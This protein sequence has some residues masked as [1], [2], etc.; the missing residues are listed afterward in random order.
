MNR[1]GTEEFKKHISNRLFTVIL[2][3]VLIIAIAA[4]IVSDTRQ[5]IK[6]TLGTLDNV[7]KTVINSIDD[8]SEKVTEKIGETSSVLL[9]KAY[10][11]RQ[12]I[13]TNGGEIS[14]QQLKKF[15][16]EQHLHD[17]LIFDESGK[18]FMSVYPE[19]I[20]FDLNAY[21]ATR[22]YMDIFKDNSI[23]IVEISAVDAD[24]DGDG[25]NYNYCAV[26][27]E[28]GKYIIEVT[29]DANDVESAILKVSVAEVARGMTCD[30]NARTMVIK[31]GRIVSA[32][33]EALIG[34]DAGAFEMSGD[35]AKGSGTFD[36]I[37]CLYSQETDGDYKVL[38]VAENSEVFARNGIGTIVK[39]FCIL[40]VY[41]ALLVASIINRKRFE[42][43]VTDRMKTEQ[44]GK[45]IDAFIRE[46]TTVYR[47][48]LETG[49]YTTLRAMDDVE[50]TFRISSDISANLMNLVN[51]FVAESD[52]ERMTEEFDL[53]TIARK[54]K[55]NPIYSVE[56][57]CLVNLVPEG[58][59]WTYDRAKLDYSVSDN[60]VGLWHRVT[61]SKI[62]ENEVLIGF[63]EDDENIIMKS[64]NDV[65]LDEFD[66]IYAVN[67]VM[68]KM[69]IVKASGLLEGSP[70]VMPYRAAMKRFLSGLDEGARE[71]F[72]KLETEEGFKEL[73]DSGD[74]AEYIY[75]SPYYGDKETWLKA[76]VHVLSEHDGKLETAIFGISPV[77]SIQ[78]KVLS[79]AAAIEHLAVEYVGVYE[80]NLDTEECSIVRIGDRMDPETRKTVQNMTMKQAFKI[81]V[82]NKVHPD[83]RHLLASLL[84]Y[85]LIREELMHKKRSSK[86]FRRMFDDGYKYCNYMVSKEEAI[87]EVPHMVVIGFMMV[88]DRV[89]SE[90]IQKEELARALTFSD[91]IMDSFVS[92]YY[93]DI[94]T[95]EQTTYA[96]T[97][98]LHEKYDDIPDYLDSLDKY[99]A[100]DVH[101][102]DREMLTEAVQPDYIRSRLEKEPYFSVT[103]R[104]ISGGT[105]KNYRCTVIRGADEDHI[106]MAFADVS[107]EVK[108]DAEVREQL[109][110]ALS[111]AQAASK[112]KSTFL[113]N[114]S[115]DIRTPM[116]SIVGYT[117]LA[118]SNIDN[119]EQ[120][121]IYLGKIMNSSN[122]L[123][124]LIN[125]VL[126]MA[127]IESG[128][129]N[130]TET[131]ESLPEILH[132]LHDI[133]ISD[134]NAKQL[135]FYI[136]TVNIRDENVIVDKTRLNQVLL[137][138]LSNA[139]KYTPSGGT[140]FFRVAET[141]VS[142][143]GYGT[144]EFHIKDSGVGM[145][146]EEIS[147]IF[148]PFERAVSADENQIV[149]TGLGMSIV[150]NI[151]DM[152]GGQ[153]E[154][155]SREGQGTE[156]TITLELK[157]EGVQNEPDLIPELKDAR[158]IVVD[159]D[160]N[161]CKSV[162]RM[163]KAIGMQADWCTSGKECLFRTEE[164]VQEGE[165][166]KV[167]IIDWQMPDMNGIETTRQVR[168]LVG[169]DVPVIILTAYDYSDIEEEAREAG[170]S[171]FIT[172]PIF[173]SDLSRTLREVCVSDDEA[174]G[175]AEDASGGA[176]AYDFS[177]K[178]ILIVED[179][180][181]NLDIAE[182]I[183]GELG[184][185]TASAINGK[186]AVEIMSDA[187]P[188]EFDLILMDI[189]MPVMNGLEAAKKIRALDNGVQDIPILALTANAF[190][191]DKVLALEAGMNEHI[192]KPLNVSVLKET[193]AKYL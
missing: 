1:K 135:D 150:K 174:D 55:D 67:L 144:Y 97:D 151:I 164:A 182:K 57:R 11:F 101:P 102:D 127:R 125:D 146:E 73:H 157:L 166:Y 96:R 180:E 178:K 130:L 112:A 5:G 44:S 60:I 103:F 118:A 48:N 172:K 117:G 104:D 75:C 15:V 14:G 175:A 18:A 108:K 54:L 124:S 123:L 23:E 12:L 121:Q 153:I 2:T 142:H 159:D 120:V 179:N 90:M 100:E 13:E 40:L 86:I 66:D 156:V 56:F 71:F 136:D 189:R 92:A 183:L 61:F 29:D 82:E 41:I 106:A 107:E 22:H 176:A 25:G 89:R 93:I 126:D 188:G 16:E 128:K 4:V 114:M 111:L 181:D 33:D 83:D 170:V 171:A 149:G 87:D 167:Y 187:K 162:S 98:E 19:G 84:D 47:V 131:R 80:L 10:A 88:D 139:I 91:F 173:Q 122:H 165:N 190:A 148:T 85:S 65:L 133:V 6:E 95:H 63:V 192:T 9:R 64:V 43:D 3:A 105:E 191:E 161:A 145:S 62:D 31:D 160:M 185:T 69:K 116:N 143:S 132:T 26:S 147:R 186:L 52:R 24:G 76:K 17:A 58:E 59:G 134:V 7:N 184:I 154:V 39:L 94:A 99:I 168:R 50:K 109:Q 46:Y 115:H 32:N 37:P 141:A 113:N 20:G 138:I 21:D 53:K 140:V 38:T 8:Y 74:T 49:E 110:S 68:D 72:S 35:S 30:Y 152:M 158:G 77:D 137:N 51:N 169:D 45:L 70:K 34:R 155:S 36:G 193:L 163:L 79:Q 177:G 27:A 78:E 81:F 129:M 119:K 28:N 42:Y